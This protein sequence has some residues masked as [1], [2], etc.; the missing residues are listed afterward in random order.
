M[1]GRG[2]G[3]PAKRIVKRQVRK[4]V[5]KKAVSSAKGAKGGGGEEQLEEVEEVDDV[6][7]VSGEEEEG[8]FVSAAPSK[9]QKHV[10]V[11]GRE[12]PHHKVCCAVM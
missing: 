7:E 6:I 12:Q 8:E 2:R 1:P 3:S 9:K 4:K 10:H 5:V 11:R